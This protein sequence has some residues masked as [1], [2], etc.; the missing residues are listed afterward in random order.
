MFEGD[1]LAAG[2]LV[3]HELKGLTALMGLH[4]HGLYVPLVTVVDVGSYKVFA[5][6]ALPI[7][8]STLHKN[9]TTS[10]ATTTTTASG[11]SPLMSPRIR[12]A[13]GMDSSRFRAQ[14]AA[15]GAALAA[16]RKD[17]KTLTSLANKLSNVLHID[18]C[19][20]VGGS[21]TDT[22]CIDPSSTSPTFTGSNGLPVLGAGLFDEEAHQGIG[23]NRYEEERER[24]RERDKGNNKTKKIVCFD[25]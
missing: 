18:V 9:Y 21:S 15:V 11:V 19:G 12:S 8:A 1:A 24:E 6:A 10:A 20:S 4:Q 16:G 5:I 7:S 3:T 2:K 14:S 25:T 17:E 23:D 13:V 22:N